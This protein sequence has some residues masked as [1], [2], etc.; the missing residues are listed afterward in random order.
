MAT[1][2]SCDYAWYTLSVQVSPASGMHWARPHKKFTGEP[3]ET[4]W[5]AVSESIYGWYINAFLKF[6]NYDICF[7]FHRKVISYILQPYDL[8][9]KVFLKFSTSKTVYRLDFSLHGNKETV[10]LEIFKIWQHFFLV[11]TPVSPCWS[12]LVQP[13]ECSRHDFMRNSQV[14]L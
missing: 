1:I 12:R 2:C 7:I 9:K 3:F 4:F 5:L 11:N 14:S 8:Y 10:N 13:Q 6:L